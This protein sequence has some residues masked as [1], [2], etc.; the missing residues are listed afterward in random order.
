MNV[1]N[2]ATSLFRLARLAAAQPGL[3]AS[4]Q[5]SLTLL[6]LLQAIEARLPAAD[7][8]DAVLPQSISNISWSMAILGLPR[9]HLLELLAG[10]AVAAMPQFKDYELSS[11]LWAFAKLGAGTAAREATGSLFWAA[12][13]HLGGRLPSV[14]MR[15]LVTVV[16][17]FATCRVRHPVLFRAVAA[18]MCGKKAGQTDG[19]E[20]SNT[21]WAFAT[22]GVRDQGLMRALGDVAER[23]LCTFKPQEVSNTLWG[24]AT[25][26]FHRPALLEH[27]SRLLPAMDLDPQH[28]ANILWAAATSDRDARAVARTV[29]TALLPRCRAC[30]R[31]FKLEEASSVLMALSRAFGRDRAGELAGPGAPPDALKLCA[32]LEQTMLPHVGSV[33]AQSL[34][35]ILESLAALGL[36]DGPLATALEREARRRAPKLPATGLVLLLKGLLAVRGTSGAALSCVASCLA[37]ECP[38]QQQEV[39]FLQHVLQQQ[40]LW[41]SSPCL[42]DRLRELA[43]RAAAGGEEVATR[44]ANG[45]AQRAPSRA[46]ARARG[47]VPAQETGCGGPG[48][49]GWCGSGGRRRGA[50]SVRPAATPSQRQADEDI[51]EDLTRPAPWGRSATAPAN[52]DEPARFPHVRWC[53]QWSDGSAAASTAV[54][55]VENLVHF[56]SSMSD[57]S[58]ESCPVEALGELAEHCPEA[59]AFARHTTEPALRPPADALETYRVRNTFLEK[60]ELPG[61]GRAGRSRARSEPPPVAA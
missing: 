30:C 25:L 8:Q 4:L 23:T 17:S 33:P 20:V 52:M 60:V 7:S 36:E 55:T 10:L 13:A 38:M 34:C 53:R 28:L 14:Q 41:R 21:I 26:G 35:R 48:P 59:P 43:W 3:Q 22:A 31:A 39:S 56:A 9:P 32:M 46:S 1:V 37:R 44:G 27:A 58:E 16:W 51:D 15:T 45:G 57:V 24:L 5:R 2:L 61:E 50:P 11:M 40:G 49:A 12:A 54:P 42:A 18:E 19:R 6:E 29:V 47:T